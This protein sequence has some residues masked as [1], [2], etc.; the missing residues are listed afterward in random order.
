MR[1]YD[2]FKKIEYRAK[3]QFEEATIQPPLRYGDRF[4]RA[5]DKYFMD[6]PPHIVP[7]QIGGVGQHGPPLRIADEHEESDSVDEKTETKNATR[8]T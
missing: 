3:N 6:V 4:R 8:R 2:I 1:H 7:H 5:M